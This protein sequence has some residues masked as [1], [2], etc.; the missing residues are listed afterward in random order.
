MNPDDPDAQERFQD[1]ARAY[2]ILSD[3]NERADYDNNP[4]S[5]DTS[6]SG[7]GSGGGGYSQQDMTEAEKQFMDVLEEIDVM[8]D[9]ASK[10]VDDLKDDVEF[11]KDS[12]GRGEVEELW[13]FAKRRK[14]R[15]YVLSTFSVFLCRHI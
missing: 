14:V 11:T 6:S 4:N 12:V 7:G 10:Y 1:I 9:V 13:Y 5:Y 15:A 8:R 3:D 2:Q